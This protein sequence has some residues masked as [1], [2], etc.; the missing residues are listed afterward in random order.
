M[1]ASGIFLPFCL[2]WICWWRLLY[3]SPSKLHQQDWQW[4]RFNWVHLTGTGQKTLRR[5]A[6]MAG[7][8]RGNWSA[9]GSAWG[10]TSGAG[11][12]WMGQFLPWMGTAFFSTPR[13]IITIINDRFQRTLQTKF[14][15]Y[16]LNLWLH[17]YPYWIRWDSTFFVHMF[18]YWHICAHIWMHW[19]QNR[20]KQSPLYVWAYS[21]LQAYKVINEH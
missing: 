16:H 1:T 4:K 20:N 9:L 10:C 8:Q 18:T 14:S 5:A 7:L 15:K 2:P 13:V 6:L 21:Y 3:L 12:G 19:Q 17:F 11:G